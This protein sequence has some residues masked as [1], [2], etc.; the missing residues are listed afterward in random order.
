MCPFARSCRAVEIGPSAPLA[1][2]IRGRARASFPIDDPTLL[3]VVR[4]HLDAHLI[5][6][7]R[8]NAAPPHPTRGISD[9]AESILQPNAKPA[10]RQDFIDLAFEGEKLFLSQ[11]SSRPRR[12]EYGRK[13]M[14][15]AGK[16]AGEDQQHRAGILHKQILLQA[17]AY[18]AGSM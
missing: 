11:L 8:A 17:N 1:L 2:E 16:P 3:Q 4:R 13:R 5:A 7:Y 12:I 6:D 15:T 10:I 18:T 9:D 14:T